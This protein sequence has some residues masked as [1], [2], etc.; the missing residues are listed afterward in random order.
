MAKGRVT[1]GRNDNLNFNRHE[2]L[3]EWDE[4]T[5]VVVNNKNLYDTLT[6]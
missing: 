6:H 2:G 1:P 5:K 4:T 3:E